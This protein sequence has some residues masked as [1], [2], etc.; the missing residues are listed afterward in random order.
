MIK[1]CPL[2]SVRRELAKLDAEYRDLTKRPMSVEKIT[3]LRQKRYD[4]QRQI[5]YVEET[6]DSC[7]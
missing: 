4:L 7:E 1:K 2:C 3:E 5:E 6:V